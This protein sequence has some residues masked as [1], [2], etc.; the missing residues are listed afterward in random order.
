MSATTYILAVL[1]A[2]MALAGGYVYLYAP[3]NLKPL[4]AT[5]NLLTVTK[6]LRYSKGMEARS[7]GEG[8]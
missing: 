8:T 5:A 2:A 7:R 1:V 3:N 4:H 6:Q